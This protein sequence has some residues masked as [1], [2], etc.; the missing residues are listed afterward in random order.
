MTRARTTFSLLAVAAVTG[1]LAGCGGDPAPSPPGSPDN[2]LVASKQVDGKATAREP[3]S[4][5]GTTPGYGKLVQ[6]QASS[7]PG[8]S[9]SPCSLVTRAQA[10]AILGT[11]LQLPLQA[12]QGPTCIYRAAKGNGMV[13]VAVQNVEFRKLAKQVQQPTKV[14]LGGR[15][16]TCGQY[17]QPTLYLPLSGGRVLTVAAPCKVAKQFASHAVKRLGA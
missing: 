3:G 9:F 8:H 12:P 15:T 14:T 16:G 5:S 13:T 11:P 7:K 10:R 17:G 2:P 1:A 4:A 6:R